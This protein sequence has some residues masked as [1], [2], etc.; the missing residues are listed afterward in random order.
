MDHV[1]K[2][3]AHAVG[4]DLYYEVTLVL[5]W[6]NNGAKSIDIDSMREKP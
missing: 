3:I 6:R 5:E 1:A 2:F 4:T